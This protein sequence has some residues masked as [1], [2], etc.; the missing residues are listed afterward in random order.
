MMSVKDRGQEVL[1]ELAM[2]MTLEETSPR[3]N[4]QAC[5]MFVR[6]ADQVGRY[7]CNE[8]LLGH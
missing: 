2:M 5:P 3:T 1:P 6:G 8:T 7:H 4:E